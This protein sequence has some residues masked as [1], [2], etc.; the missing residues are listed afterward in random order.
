[1]IRFV[2][3]SGA[4]VGANFAFFD[5]VTDTFVTFNGTQA[6]ND[7]VEFYVDYRCCGAGDEGLAR[8]VNLIPK[9]Y[10]RTNQQMRRNI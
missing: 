10:R 4:D 2:D 8:Y 1:V 6:W 9:Q 3:L 7:D 5:T